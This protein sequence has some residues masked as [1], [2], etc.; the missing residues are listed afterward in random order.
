MV[1][2]LNAVPAICVVPRFAVL[3]VV[4]TEEKQ[5]SLDGIKERRRQ[6]LD[7][8]SNLNNIEIKEKSRDFDSR[9]NAVGCAELNKDLAHLKE[10]VIRKVLEKYSCV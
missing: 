7:M 1:R 9:R 10:I 3:Q 2:S 6:K 5:Q 8:L 4:M